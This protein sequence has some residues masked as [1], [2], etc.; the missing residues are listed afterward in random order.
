MSSFRAYR[1]AWPAAK[2][3]TFDRQSNG[4]LFP[5]SFAIDEWGLTADASQNSGEPTVK[6]MII[7]TASVLACF[8]APL[9]AQAQGIIGGGERGAEVGGRAAGPVG[10][11]VGGV[12]GGAAGGVVGGVRGVV[13]AP[14]H[15]HYG[16]YHYDHH[17]H[18]H[19]YY[20]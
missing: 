20:R 9:S 16:G 19:H 14:R 11:V 4:P 5:K 13:G 15:R 6:T 12:V 1:A 3:V 7:L 8:A 17:H 10:G 2:I 18:H